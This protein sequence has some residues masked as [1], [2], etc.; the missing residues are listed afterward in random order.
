M[1][2]VNGFVSC[3][4]V[5]VFLK[6]DFAEVLPVVEVL[7]VLRA[8]SLETLVNSNLVSWNVFKCTT[9][10]SAARVVDIVDNDRQAVEFSEMLW[11][12]HDASISVNDLW[13][14]M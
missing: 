13:L 8:K 2:F 6:F 7:C 9:W 12:K 5:Q 14:F 3:D 4:Q 10:N 11:G 1:V